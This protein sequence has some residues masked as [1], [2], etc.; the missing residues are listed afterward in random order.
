MKS[1]AKTIHTELL[2]VA[3][4]KSAQ[5]ADHSLSLSLDTRAQRI[6]AYA[7]NAVNSMVQQVGYAF[8]C[9]VQLNLAKAELPFGQF[10]KWV[11]E[12]VSVRLPDGSAKPLGRATAHRWRALAEGVQ[13]GNDGLR[14]LVEKAEQHLLANGEFSEPDRLK[15]LQAVHDVT[16]GKSISDTYR[17]FGVVR[18]KVHQKD[19]DNSRKHAPTAEDQKKLN[20]EITHRLANDARAWRTTAAIQKDCETSDLSM[21]LD[22]LVSTSSHIRQL[23][24][25]RRSNKPAGRDRRSARSVPSQMSE[26]QRAEIALAARKR[27]ARERAKQGKK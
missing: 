18:D 23:M 2:P 16:D 13:T 17:D 14:T 10:E 1:L 7:Q 27:W 6:T 20:I 11:E 12:N 5:S 21:L 9:G 22:E 3:S 24:K 15:I 8:L 19:R 26:E 25:S 4:A